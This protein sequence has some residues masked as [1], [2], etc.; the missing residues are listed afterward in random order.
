MA[1]AR[2]SKRTG[3]ILVGAAGVV[4]IV[5]I[6]VLVTAFWVPPKWAPKNLDQ[7]SAQDGVRKVLTA[8]YQ[9]GTVTDV[10]CPAKQKV[11]KGKSFTCSAK[12]GG[13]QQKIKVTFLDD[14]G[15]YEVARPAV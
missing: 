4:V 5:G 1:K 8:D 7:N 13:Q 14:D 3:P 6:I 12:V 11:A 2:K 15:K 9:A 10:K